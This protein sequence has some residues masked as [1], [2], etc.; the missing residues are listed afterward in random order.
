[1]MP[2]CFIH[3]S[4]SSITFEAFIQNFDLILK[5]SKCVRKVSF[6]LNIRDFSLKWF[7]I[8]FLL[9]KLQTCNLLNALND[10]ISCGIVELV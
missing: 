8:F 5:I 1:M 10:F 3:Q 4:H 7:N 6:T 9:Q 2:T